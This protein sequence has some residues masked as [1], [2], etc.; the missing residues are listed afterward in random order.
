MISIA[1][2]GPVRHHFRVRERAAGTACIYW[3]IVT[4]NAPK[5]NVIASHDAQTEQGRVR[6]AIAAEAFDAVS[7]A[8]ATLLVLAIVHL[9][10]DTFLVS[11]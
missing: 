4:T 6:A 9:V 8:L 2:F 10:A 1:K 11:S 3:P 5:G 7:S